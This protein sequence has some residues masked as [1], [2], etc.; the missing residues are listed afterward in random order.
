MKSTHLLLAGA[1]ALGIIAP[2]FAAEGAKAKSGSAAHAGAGGQ[3]VKATEK[4]AAWVAK[5]RASYPLKVCLTSDERLGAMG[6][7]A[8]F[9]Y[10]AKGQPDRLVLFCCDGCEEDFN[11]EPAKYLAKLDAAAKK[12]AA[13]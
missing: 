1:L 9:I 13:K 12:P 6:E 3:L 10:R 2:V 11:K 7:N 8:E 5:A 4:D